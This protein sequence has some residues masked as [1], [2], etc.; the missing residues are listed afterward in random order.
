MTAK[1]AL[2]AQTLTKRDAL[3]SEFRIEAALDVA[4][5]VSALAI[6]PGQIV[7]AYWPIRSELDVRPLVHAL[8]QKGAT[9]ALP[10]VI[11][12]ET[13]V[14]RRYQQAQ[15]LVPAG[16][17]TMA[18]PED[19]PTV[20]PAVMLVPLAAFDIT[21]NRIGYGAGHYDRAIAKLIARGRRPRL[22]GMAFECQRIDA[23]PAEDHDI[24]L[25]A[26]LTERGLQTCH[27]AG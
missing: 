26:V 10:A 8:M 12:R 13:I 7:S 5:Q 20:D 4:A 25:D 14:F 17:G 1:Q 9:M 18:P 2:R 11:D 19:A 24:A 23:V 15:I 21:G 22:I 6:E 16:F 27:S 3:T